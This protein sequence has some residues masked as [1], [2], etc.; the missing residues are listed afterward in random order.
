ML[1]IFPENNKTWQEEKAW[2]SFVFKWSKHQLLASK[3][4]NMQ[5]R[6]KNEWWLNQDIIRKGTENFNYTT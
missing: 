6:N 5:D 4:N 1:S 2:K 3:E